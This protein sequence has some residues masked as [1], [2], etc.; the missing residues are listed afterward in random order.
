MSV[1]SVLCFVILCLFFVV[2]VCGLLFM[3]L[4][5]MGVVCG[6]LVIM[7]VCGIVLGWFM[8]LRIS[9]FLCVVL[10]VAGLLL[11]VCGSLFIYVWG[12]CLSV[13][14]WFA[15]VRDV[16]YVWRMSLCVFA[17][18]CVRVVVVVLTSTCVLC[19]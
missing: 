11:F 8:C 12:G 14:I 3:Y 9:V 18:V 16:V 17:V 15:F 5:F 7:T 13:F 1:V 10:G 2:L 6:L 19:V 4:L